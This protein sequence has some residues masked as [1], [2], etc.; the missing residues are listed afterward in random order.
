MPQSVPIVRLERP[1]LRRERD[2]LRGVQASRA[3]H[4]GLV[5]PPSTGE[6]YRAYL[7]RSRRRSQESFFVASADDDGLIGVIN[8]NDIVLYS[9]RSASLGYYAFVPYAGRG[10]MREAL[11]LVVGRCFGEMRLHR[12]EANIQP[13]NGRSIALVERLGFTLE[14]FSRRYLKIGGRW[15]DH[16][17]WALLA[18]DWRPR[19]SR[20]R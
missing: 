8:V 17:R 20:P 3:L 7:R 14:G 9:F 18:E 6:E 10:L 4:A 16:Q 11:R 13:H 1:S 2:F 19:E 5:E 15:R 12:L